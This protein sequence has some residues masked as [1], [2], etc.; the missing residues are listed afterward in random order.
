MLAL[1]ITG[2]FKRDYKREKP[3]RHTDLDA[4]FKATVDLLVSETPLPVANRDHPLK[5][6]WKGCRDCHLKPDLV[7]TYRKTRT[8]IE[9]LRLGSH[10]ELFS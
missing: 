5:G 8:S 9:L 7:L 1:E 4:V 10:S 3:G 6:D 2:Q